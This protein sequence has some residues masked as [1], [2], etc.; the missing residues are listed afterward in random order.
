M[1]MTKPDQ[2]DAVEQKY[3]RACSYEI[4]FNEPLIDLGE[5]AISSYFSDK[6]EDLPTY[7]LVLGRCS[8]CGTNSCIFDSYVWETNMHLEVY[9]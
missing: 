3:C 4:N 1:K 9:I 6:D 7:P 8:N 2:S 5:Q